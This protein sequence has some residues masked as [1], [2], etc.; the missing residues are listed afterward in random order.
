MASSPRQIVP[1]THE[2]INWLL[3]SETEIPQAFLDSRKKLGTVVPYISEQLWN[4][5]HINWYLNKHI[6]DLFNIPD[7]IEALVLFKKLFKN[8]SITKYDLYQKPFDFKP[9]VLEAIEAKENYDEGNARSKLIMMQSLNIP[10]T[11]YIKPAITKASVKTNSSSEVKSMVEKA[12]ENKK[13]QSLI[14]EEN[15]HYISELSQEIID[16]EELILFDVSLLKKTNRVLFIFIDKRNHKKYFIKPFMAKIY[17]SKQDGVINNDYIEVLDPDKFSGY[18]MND[19]RM[20]TKLKYILGHS[21]KK[22]IND[23]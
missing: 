19:I 12:I 5:P 9:K 3:S 4:K 22:V 23:V 6:N 21:Y 8:N 2:I 13:V 11:N 14:P 17:I 16:Q 7:P 20:Y 10:T 1:K 15:N 18:I